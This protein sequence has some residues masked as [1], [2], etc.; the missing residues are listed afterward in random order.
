MPVSQ[1]ILRME[2]D[3]NYSLVNDT[4]R[5]IIIFSTLKNLHENL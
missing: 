2:G 5:N 4:D 1:D 3:E